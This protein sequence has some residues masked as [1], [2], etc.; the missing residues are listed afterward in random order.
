MQPHCDISTKKIYGC[1][2]GSWYYE[3]EKAHIIFNDIYS[4]LLMVQQFIFIFWMLCITANNVLL[5]WLSFAGYIG[6]YIYEEY[7]CNKF[8]SKKMK[9]QP[10]TL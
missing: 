3:H 5:S 2:E 8:A 1:K 10:K 7:W 9:Q 6:I 4:G